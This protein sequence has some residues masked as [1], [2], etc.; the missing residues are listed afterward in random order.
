MCIIF[1]K[2]KYNVKCYDAI[3]VLFRYVIINLMLQ[4][5][6]K[7]HITIMDLRDNFYLAYL[8]EVIQMQG[9]LRVVPVYQQ[10]TQK[11]T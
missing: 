5:L 11:D 1:R 9:Y 6:T 2:N 4:S 8:A 7:R 3:E 10:T